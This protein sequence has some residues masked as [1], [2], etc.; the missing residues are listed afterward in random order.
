MVHLKVE[1]FCLLCLPILYALPNGRPAPEN[2]TFTSPP[3]DSYLRSTTLMDPDMETLFRNALPN[4]LDT[5]VAFHGPS[6]A[7]IITGD[8]DAMWLRDA[9]NQLRPYIP[10]VSLD[11]NLSTLMVNVCRRMSNSVLY[12]SYANAFNFDSLSPGDHQ[13]DV[14]TPRMRWGV[15]EGKYELDSLAAFMGHCSRTYNALVDHSSM[16][17]DWLDTYIEAVAVATSTIR[18]QQMSTEEEVREGGPAYKFQRTT[19][20]S[21]DT[22]M[23]GGAGVPAHRTGM[24]KCMFRPSDDAVTL[25]FHVP[26]NAMASVELTNTAEVLSAV[27]PREQESLIDELNSLSNEIRVGIERFGR[28]VHPVTKET[29]YA[30]EV[31]GYGGAVFMD[32]ANVPSLLSLPYLGYVSAEDSVY[33]ATRSYVL[34]PETNPFYFRGESLEGIGGPHVGYGM[35]WPMSLIVRGLTSTDPSEI[36]DC[37]ENV[38]KTTGGTGFVHE[39]VDVEDPTHYTRD[40]F[41][42]ANGLF[43]EL[44][45]KALTQHPGLID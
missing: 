5:T 6:D 43:G 1:L 44:V 12:D 19:S 45:M 35:A 31:D 21:T 26:A 15:Y 41:A 42:W 13:D 7:F 18:R 16:F 37:L 10:F 11:P 33:K 23:Q 24:S 40:W 22:L 8:I 3:V 36:Q 32:D 17:D 39:S 14:R 30:Y 25:P 38:T 20:T 2:R 4:T 29:V 27:A 9:A 28:V 34:S